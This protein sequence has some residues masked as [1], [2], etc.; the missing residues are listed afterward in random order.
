[1]SYPKTLLV[2]LFLLPTLSHG[3]GNIRKSSTLRAQEY[4]QSWR[5]YHSIF[6]VG[7]KRGEEDAV[8][9]RRKR[10]GQVFF[11]IDAYINAYIAHSN[12]VVECCILF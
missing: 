4:A 2:L 6:A 7:A 12:Y 9:K 10:R 11:N 5:P 1:M 8:S 3:F